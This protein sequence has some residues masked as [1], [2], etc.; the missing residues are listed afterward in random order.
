MNIK[1]SKNKKT[2][3][4]YRYFLKSNFVGV[5]RLLVLIYSND[6]DNAKRFKRNY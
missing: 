3:N 5:N 2:A 1:K 6:D 4:E